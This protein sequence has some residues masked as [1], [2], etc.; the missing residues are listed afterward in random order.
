MLRSP[1][2]DIAL[3]SVHVQSGIAEGTLEPRPGLLG[4]E[5]AARRQAWT[6]WGQGWGVHW[7]NQ[8]HGVMRYNCADS[9]D[10]TNAASYFAAVQASLC[11]CCW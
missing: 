4:D 3:I 11:R 5:E 2:S 6:P 10:R 9:L 1:G 8:Q 7:R